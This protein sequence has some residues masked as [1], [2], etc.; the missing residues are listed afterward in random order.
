MFPALAPV[1]T[2]GRQPAV[3]TAQPSPESAE[4]VPTNPSLFAGGAFS[5]PEY[6]APRA[7]GPFPD[8]GDNADATSQYPDKLAAAAQAAPGGRAL[9][10]SRYAAHP[11]PLAR[12][13]AAA[14]CAVAAW[15]DDTCFPVVTPAVGVTYDAYGNRLATDRGQPVPAGTVDA[16]GVLPPYGMS[17]PDGTF[18]AP[19]VFTPDPV[20]S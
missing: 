8:L 9:Y 4:D 17:V 15:D 7:P 5:R 3:R 20:S 11:S 6:D 10:L 18:T 14:Q 13:D 2:L 19:L 1:P 12:F 16:A